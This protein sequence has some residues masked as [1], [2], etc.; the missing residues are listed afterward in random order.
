[1]CAVSER[2]ASS[3]SRAHA[4]G[5]EPRREAARRATRGQ[6]RTRR[7]PTRYS[8]PA[9]SSS[10]S[11][12]TA[13]LIP[14]APARPRRSPSTSR[15]APMSAAHSPATAPSASSASPPAAS[16]PLALAS[17]TT[18]LDRVARPR[19]RQRPRTSTTRTAPGS[20]TTAT[21]SPVHSASMR[22]Q[23]RQQ[24]A[25]RPA[26][27]A[28][29]LTGSPPRAGRAAARASGWPA[30]R[31]VKLWRGGGEVVAHSSVWASHGSGPAGLPA[32]LVSATL[33][34]KT[35]DRQ[36]D[37]ARAD[38]GGGVPARPS[39]RPASSRRP[40]AACRRSRARTAG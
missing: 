36:R 1:M 17:G 33:T 2:P 9:A 6:P 39:R 20:R 27:G 16:R 22:G 15:P 37:D 29:F 40:A 31:R 4:E 24:R 32:T 3:A 12:T 35:S 18:P 19:R 25:P 38:G 28:A 13:P 11:R 10:A 23:R 34:M 21:R 8:A 26:P 7:A 14:S 5:G 30:A